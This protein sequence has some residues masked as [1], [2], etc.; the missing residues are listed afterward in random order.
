[1]QLVIT[2]HGHAAQKLQMG[3][4]VKVSF[5][6]L[7]WTICVTMY[8]LEITLNDA[9]QICIFRAPIGKP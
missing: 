3:C 5:P 6:E 2:K 9:A 4:D 7:G 8:H 1:M